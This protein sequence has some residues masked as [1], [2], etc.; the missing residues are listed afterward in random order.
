LTA[1]TA[2]TA[3]ERRLARGPSAPPALPCAR[4]RRPC[5]KQ[6][7]A[8]TS[9]GRRYPS[10]RG[11]ACLARRIAEGRFPARE[12]HTAPDLVRP[13]PDDG[14]GGRLRSNVARAKRM[15]GFSGHPPPWCGWAAAGRGACPRYRRRRHGLVGD[16]DGGPDAGCRLHVL[17]QEQLP[18]SRS[19][20]LLHV[21]SSDNL[22]PSFCSVVSPFPPREAWFH[23]KSCRIQPLL[24]QRGRGSRWVM[25]RHPSLGGDGDGDPFSSSSP[26]SMVPAHRRSRWRWPSVSLAHAATL[27]ASRSVRLQIKKAGRGS[28]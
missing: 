4:F 28:R 13:G 20:S 23:S 10:S 15:A 16:E 2:V 12:W 8:R 3:A 5:C 24:L 26:A 21:G 25:A 17:K 11:C 9:D 18:A 19:G 22:S 6:A 27:G 14:S 1:V 7:L